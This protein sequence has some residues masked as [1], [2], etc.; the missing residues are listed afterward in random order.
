MIGASLVVIWG[1]SCYHQID[2]SDRGVVQRF[3]RFNSVL[4]PGWRLTFPWP[5][6]KLTKVNVS[7]LN[8]REY[9]SKVLTAD[10]NLVML[11]AAVQYQNADPAKVLFQ[12][13]DVD[14]TLEEVS[15]SAMREVV[16][17]ATL[18]EVLGAGRQR[19]T[20]DTRDRIQRMLDGYTSGIRVTSVNLTNVQVPD[21]VVPAQREAN[22]AIEDKERYS[23]EAQAYANDILPKAQGQAQ[24]QLQDAEA[25]KAQVVS[26]A[27]GDVAR[28]NSVY[29]AYAAAPEI[30]RK[31]MYIETIEQVYRDSK[32]VIIDTKGGSGGNMIYLPLDKLLERTRAGAQAAPATPPQLEELPE[33]S[34][35][36]RSRRE[37]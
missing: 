13:K 9:S 17:Q 35:D 30:T 22:K 32:K 7:Q 25:Y 1:I 20:T 3:G 37:R 2:A 24:R 21:D 8:S 15:D 18:E 11:R 10:V 34:V 36:G 5:I 26:L 28:F 23:K 27:E 14:K 31:R 6:D 33:V 12:V 16:G 19:I 29:A 4:Q